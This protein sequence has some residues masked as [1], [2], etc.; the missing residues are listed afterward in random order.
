MPSPHQNDVASTAAGG[1]VEQP[2]SRLAAQLL[3]NHANANIDGLL[4]MIV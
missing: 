4:V 2:I 3:D 1:G